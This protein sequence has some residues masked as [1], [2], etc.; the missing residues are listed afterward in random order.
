MVSCV[1]I[2]GR[3]RKICAGDLRLKIGLFNREITGNVSKTTAYNASFV[4]GITA[5]AMLLTRSGA[6]IINGVSVTT[7]PTHDFYIRYKADIES[8]KWVI[9]NEVIYDVIEVEN[10]E[11][12][13][14]FLKISCIKKGTKKAAG[15]VAS[16]AKFSING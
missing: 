15:G 2:N 8:T 13:N 7:K 10:L 14:E 9:Y 4:G 1:S 12:R 3:K 16:A 5:S 6:Q 11:E